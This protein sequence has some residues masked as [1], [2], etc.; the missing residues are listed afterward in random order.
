MPACQG[1][2]ANQV[3]FSDKTSLD[4]PP[5]LFAQGLSPPVT[6]HQEEAWMEQQQAPAGGPCGAMTGHPQPPLL[7]MAS[8]GHVPTRRPRPR[9]SMPSQS[10]PGPREAHRLDGFWRAQYLEAQREVASR[11]QPAGGGGQAGGQTR[12]TTAYSSCLASDLP[13]A[14]CIVSLIPCLCGGCLLRP[15]PPAAALGGLPAAPLRGGHRRRP[16]LHHRRR[17]QRAVAAWCSGPSAP[18][19]AATSPA[20]SVR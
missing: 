8:P 20:T 11:H 10:V 17:T 6:G 19:G 7:T 14:F 1:Y 13:S 15:V 4:M 3:P 12:P 16:S 9:A 5:C 2:D 18:H